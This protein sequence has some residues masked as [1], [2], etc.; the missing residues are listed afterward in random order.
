MENNFKKEIKI[1]FI[2]EKKLYLHS[3]CWAPILKHG[4]LT[5]IKNSCEDGYKITVIQVII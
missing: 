3:T 4:V 1:I 5:I 2:K